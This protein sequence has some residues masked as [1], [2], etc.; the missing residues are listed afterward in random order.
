MTIRVLP[1]AENIQLVPSRIDDKE[2]LTPL[3]CN[4]SDNAVELGPLSFAQRATSHSSWV[5]KG[6]HSDSLVSSVPRPL[7]YGWY[8]DSDGC[9]L[10]GFPAPGNFTTNGAGGL[11]CTSDD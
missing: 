8:P 2:K 3:I 1:K 9:A 7:A 6:A 11:L 4:S 10:N 5:E